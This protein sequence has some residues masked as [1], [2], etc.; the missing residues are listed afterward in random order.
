MGQVMEE[1]VNINRKKEV[2]GK[3]GSASIE[4]EPVV[5]IFED[6]KREDFSRK[7][8]DTV[9]QTGSRIDSSVL[10]KYTSAASRE[11][12]IKTAILNLMSTPEYQLC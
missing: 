8:T 3:G 4:W 1:Q 12:F 2:V 7:I 9:L 11:D 10:D 5:K 6:I